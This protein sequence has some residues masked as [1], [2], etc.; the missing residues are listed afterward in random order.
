MI[1]RNFWRVKLVFE[2]INYV[3]SIRF[4]SLSIKEK[5]RVLK[6]EVIDS[7]YIFWKV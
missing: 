5:I 7:L 4:N 6:E 3:K 1:L 2:N